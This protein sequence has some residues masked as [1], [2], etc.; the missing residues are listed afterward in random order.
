[1]K[2]IILTVCMVLMSIL[3]YSQ[4]RTVS[5]VVLKNGATVTGYV[6]TQPDGSFKVETPAGDIFF[7]SASEV[8]RI[9]ETEGKRD[10]IIEAKPGH[11]VVYKRGGS[12]RFCLDDKKLGLE[13][14]ASTKGWKTYKGAQNLRG[15]GYGVAATGLA[16]AAT[17]G[18]YWLTEWDNMG[19][20]IIVAGGTTILIG[21][22]TM[23]IFGNKKLKKIVQSYNNNPGYAFDFGSQ[24]HGVGFA[25]TF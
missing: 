1:M 21:G 24:K 11:E 22:I 15:W 5:D 10:I 13:D 20:A 16:T 14:F 25:L 18:V 23:I 9:K 6:T 4:V 19:G 8:K 7:F 2:K 3:A 17:G 12:I